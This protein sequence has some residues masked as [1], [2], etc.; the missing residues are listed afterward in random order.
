MWETYAFYNH[1]ELRQ[2]RRYTHFHGKDFENLKK[3][4]PEEAANVLHAAAQLA[5]YL[6]VT[7]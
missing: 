2:Q 1:M 5:V 3:T 7:R 4:N 6:L